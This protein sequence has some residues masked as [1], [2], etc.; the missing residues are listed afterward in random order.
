MDNLSMLIGK[1]LTPREWLTYYRNTWQRNV[2]ARLVDVRCDTLLAEKNPEERVMEYDLETGQPTGA[3][4]PVSQRLE[5]RKVVVQDAVDVVI[6]I[7]T[8]LALND[9]ELAKTWSPEALVPKVKV[10]ETPKDESA[11]VPETTVEET[12]AVEGGEEQA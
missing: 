11:P 12:P 4:I 6:A 1:A 5:T 3:V 7:D 10:E 8:L 9:E 2:I